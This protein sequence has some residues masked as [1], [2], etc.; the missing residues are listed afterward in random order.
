MSGP[1]LEAEGLAK[2]FGA[3]TALDNVD[4]S[5]EAGE[6][7]AL[8][9]PSGCGKTTL[10]RCFAG[11][12]RPDEGRILLDGEDITGV[13]PNRRPLCM[14]FQ[15][16]A[17]FPHMTVGRNVA[18]GLE[19]ERLQKP[20]IDQRV[21]EILEITGLGALRDRKPHQLSGGQR[22]RVALARALVKKPKVLLLDEPL[23]ALDRGLR[24][25]MQVELK[26]A[27]K[28]S[29][30]AF[31]VVTH[32]QEEALGLADR[33]AVLDHGRI[34]QIGGPRDIY[35]RPANTFVA[36]F[37]GENNI[38]PVV[39]G[40]SFEAAK[41]NIGALLRTAGDRVNIIETAYYLQIRPERLRLDREPNTEPAAFDAD[42]IETVFHG[43][44][45][46]AI[47][48]V[49][50]SQQRL[51]A[52]L[53]AADADRVR[54]VPGDRLTCSAL[55]EHIQKVETGATTAAHSEKGKRQM[56]EQ[57]TIA[58]FPEAAYGPALNSVGIAQAVQTL[59]HK[60]VFLSDPGFVDVYREYGFEAH[61]VNLSEPMPAEQMAKFWED[62]INGHIPN[63]RKS[64]YDQIDNY[65]KDCW[66]AIVDSAKWAQ[67]DLPGVLDRVKPD[68][69]CVDNVILFPAIKQ[70]GKPWVRII[71]CSENEIEDPAI[72]PHLSGCAE[73]D[74]EGHKRYRDRFNEVIKPIHDDFNAFLASTGE[75]PYPIGQF[76]EAS[77]FMNMLLYPEPA[78]FKRQHPL[79]ASQFQ[80]LEGCVRT[81]KPYEVPAFAANNDK[82]L[83][84]VSFGSLGCGDTDLL[85]RIIATIGKLPYRAL[86]NVGGYMDQYSDVPPIVIIDKWF[87][88]PSVIPLVDA[89]IHHGGN[90]SFTECLYFGKPAIIMPYVWD[91]HDNATRVQETGHGFKMPRYD[92]TDADLA[93]KLDACINDPAIRAKLASTSAHMKS[94][95]GPAKA[96]GILDELLKKGRYDA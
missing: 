52:R 61:P 94:Q 15:S 33:V 25:Q 45:V 23:S 83:L 62:F 78:K 35:D 89:A 54:P 43:S 36:R 80:Y 75:E 68:L 32:D 26:R 12:E 11:F 3:L 9:G 18:Y 55:P 51:I 28:D 30:I 21:D 73:N 1:I 82:P 38:I 90:N 91:G 48:E 34:Q 4:V 10:L 79:A 44:D 40:M 67:K 60:A 6:F 7:Y 93:Q 87:P 85:K 84:Y 39:P 50:G 20:E 5:I 31:V 29:G 88:Q 71:S 13:R 8:L 27:Q 63:F 70:F 76:F 22:Q 65:V 74:L 81:E 69:I 41:A 56:S 96:A 66:T 2:R 42:V 46:K 49:A 64:P 72:P 59:G 47:L 14:M 92:W 57:K 17:L 37:V 16:Y 19:M 95:K 86:V 24:E 58:F 77:P 53:S